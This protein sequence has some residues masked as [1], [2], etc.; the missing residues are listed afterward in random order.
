LFATVCVVI[1]SIL[2]DTSIVKTSVYSG[3]LQGCTADI[4]LF[5]IISLIYAMGQYVIV[6]ATILRERIRTRTMVIVDKSA[7]I[8]QYILIAILLFT[9]IQMINFKLQFNNTKN[10]NMD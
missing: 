9:I 7:V 8:L 4:L 6:K 10:S 5:T 1:V 3:G 2:I